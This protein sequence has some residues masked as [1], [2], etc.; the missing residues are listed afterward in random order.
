[1]AV[2]FASGSFALAN[3]GFSAG[4]IAVI[5]GAG[6]SVGNWLM[7]QAKDRNLLDFLGL[8]VDS[9]ILRKGLLDTGAL[10]QR[11]DQ[12]LHLLRNGRR[13]T[14][15][16][17]N[18]VSLIPSIDK[19]TWLMTLITAGLDAALDS[20][21]LRR[22]MSELLA[23][24]FVESV[25]GE[26]YH[27]HEAGYHIQGWHSVACVRGITWK[28]RELWGMLGRDGKHQPGFVPESDYGD[29]LRL[30]IWITTGADRTFY[31]S[32]SDTFCVARVLEE[33]G[34]ELRTAEDGKQHFDESQ[35]VVYWN[36][37]CPYPTGISIAKS[38]YR[39][40]MRIPLEFME[41]VASLFPTDRNKMRAL[42][43]EGRRSV[44]KDGLKLVPYCNDWN[45]SHQS[46]SGSL[47][48][49]INFHY[50]VV[51]SSDKPIPHIRGET[52]SLAS[53]LLPIKSSKVFKAFQ[54]VVDGLG[55]DATYLL[56][57]L[58][59]YNE[60][61]QR[62]A[63]AACEELN[64][65]QYFVLGYFYELLRPLLDTSQLSTQEAFGSWGWYDLEC[66]NLIKTVVKDMQQRC[67]NSRYPKLMSF[68]RR[69]TLMLIGFLFAGADLEQIQSIKASSIGIIGKLSLIS[70][71]LLGVSEKSDQ[72]G[73][74]S[75][76]DID[77]SS[78][79]CSAIGIIAPGVPTA[80]REHESNKGLFANIETVT[81]AEPH[82][83]DFEDFTT[84]IEPDWGY[85]VQ[86]CLIAYR[87]RG[88]IVHRF[89][90]QQIEVDIWCRMRQSDPNQYPTADIMPVFSRQNASVEHLSRYKVAT[91][92]CHIVFEDFHGGL[93]AL[94]SNTMAEDVET[95]TIIPKV[96]ETRGC[97]NA[98]VCISAMY[99][100]PST[101]ESPVHLVSSLEDITQAVKE[102][103]RVI[104]VI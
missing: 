43:E 41:E 63:V 61:A 58:T 22:L 51:S 69:E 21:V 14:M 49:N 76:L 28:A 86:T 1:M 104:I 95:V 85:D 10:H 99:M 83:V 84:H 26:E 27:Q 97:P 23:K 62:M 92:I 56:H 65:L 44:K 102:L 100:V 6:R 91:E 75:L 37:Q 73:R 60:D 82:S 20:R 7:A 34:L 9:V 74:F 18:G 93:V 55:P 32:S 50:A 77:P 13:M 66:L 16:Q 90:P 36:I 45:S 29:I 88:R 78:I 79:P 42:F 94:P 70:S 17:N 2:S 54:I 33:L 72:L 24:L 40:G 12:K 8:D 48:D 71:A 89:D 3:W 39:R 5:A 59:E 31:T 87:H 30:L 64:Q 11:W 80:V 53:L 98:R 46:G 103:K 52:F 57:L 38:K 35:I 68:N 25:T 47:Q 4:D 67:R 81:W 101:K 96:I 19:F 15:Q